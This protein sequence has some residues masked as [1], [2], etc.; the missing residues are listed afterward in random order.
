VLRNSEQK[1]VIAKRS[2]KHVALKENDAQQ[3]PIHRLDIS[4]NSVHVF[5]FVFYQEKM[6][7]SQQ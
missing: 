6:N 1:I 4:I 5:C 2:F 7:S 3:F